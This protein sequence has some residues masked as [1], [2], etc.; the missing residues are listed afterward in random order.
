MH[1]NISTSP[2]DFST[3]IK[4]RHS[5]IRTTIAQTHQQKHQT[6]RIKTLTYYEYAKDRKVLNEE[7]HTEEIVG[8]LTGV[9]VHPLCD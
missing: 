5:L 9:P 2:V 8:E 7:L 4:K 1:K 3:S 6:S